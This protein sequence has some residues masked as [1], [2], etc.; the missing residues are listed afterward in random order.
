MATDNRPAHMRPGADE[1]ARPLA[2]AAACVALALAAVQPLSM[3]A[4]APGADPALS[5]RLPHYLMMGQN[6]P[7]TGAYLGSDAEFSASFPD[8]AERGREDLRVA[9]G[10]VSERGAAGE[11]VFLAKKLAFSLGDGTFSWSADGGAGFLAAVPPEAGG[12]TGLLRSLYW[13]GEWLGGASQAA[14]RAWAQPLW[15]CVVALWVPLGAALAGR[16]CRLPGGAAAA[17]LA[18]VG[19]IAYL[20]LLEDRARYLFALGPVLVACAALGARELAGLIRRRCRASGREAAVSGREA[21]AH[22]DR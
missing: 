18:V 6:E 14:F 15:L 7:M 17:A 3:A 19:V 20:L 16:R 1:P 8:P 4:V 22:G 12:L 13:R 5:Q 2:P 11:L 10:R 21:R 9:L